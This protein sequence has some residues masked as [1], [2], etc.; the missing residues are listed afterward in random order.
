MD[1]GWTDPGCKT[2]LDHISQFFRLKYLNSLMRIREGQYSVL[3]RKKFWSGIREGKILIQDPGWKKFGSGIR[4]GKN[5]GQ[6]TGMEKIRIRDKH[7]GSATLDSSLPCAACNSQ[8]SA[9]WPFLRA[10]KQAQPPPSVP[11]GTA[12]SGTWIPF[13]HTQTNKRNT[14]RTKEKWRIVHWKMAPK[15][16]EIW[17]Q[18]IWKNCAKTIE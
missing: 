1:P 2:L 13:L 5:S 4:D 10:P 8:P 17:R 18:N 7:P 11:P 3:G 15:Q 14:N 16:S 12:A 9:G 6:G